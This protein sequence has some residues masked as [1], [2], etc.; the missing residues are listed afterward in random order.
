ICNRL[1]KFKAFVASLDNY[2]QI[3]YLYMKA[4]LHWTPEDLQDLLKK[5][6]DMV[7]KEDINV[8]ALSRRCPDLNEAA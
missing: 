2:P 7:K 4:D 1:K 5:R 6:L 8:C 3:T